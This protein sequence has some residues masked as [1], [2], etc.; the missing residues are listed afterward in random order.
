MSQQI[1]KAIQVFVKSA[2]KIG[3][4]S[5]IDAIYTTNRLLDI[6]LLEKCTV[7]IEEVAIKDLLDAMDD[8]VNLG[9]VQGFLKNS[10]S[11]KE[12][13]QAKI[14]DLI[15]PK[16]STVNEKFWYLYDYN[17]IR[18]TD[19]FYNLSQQNDYIKTRNIQKNIEYTSPSEYGDMEITINLSKPELSPKEIAKAKSKEWTG[20]PKCALCFENEGYRGHE[21]HP[22]RQNHRIIRMQINNQ[23][24]G[25]QFSPYAYYNEH[26]IFI[27]KVHQPM[28][29]NLKTFENLFSIVDQL[30]HYFIGS[31][32]DIPRVGGSILSHSHYQGGRHIFPMNRAE[33]EYEIKLGTDQNITAAILKWP[34]SVI[35]LKSDDKAGLLSCANRILKAWQNYDNE[36]LDILASSKGEPHN[37]ITPIARKDNQG[38][39]ELY[40]VLRNNRT[41]EEFPD[42]IFHPHP[43]VQHIKKENIGL[44]E[45]M[46]LAILPPRL[47][48]ALEQI[49]AYLMEELPLEDVPTVHQDWAS[50]LN[51]LYQNQSNE[52][53]EEFIQKQVGMVFTRILEDSS[54]FKRDEKGQTAFKD[55]LDRIK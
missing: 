34:M 24:F 36:D 18:A 5:E 55:F 17:P 22:A 2:I 49:T 48:V 11:E 31:N 9:L 16:P 53:V 1:E 44:I 4:L 33:M 38:V 25:F 20:Y 35:R 54:V 30:P 6:F 28:I 45:V 27:N 8:L 13:F 50:N 21:S 37:T 15:T 42:G 32:A 10:Q 39:Y 29:I 23:N 46:G 3:R 52:P 12:I 43:D 47:K 40:L 19:Y 41:T 7:S 51:E 14:M 26:S